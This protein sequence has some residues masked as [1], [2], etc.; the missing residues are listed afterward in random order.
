MRNLDAMLA[1]ANDYNKMF[2][3]MD[4][5]G[6]LVNDILAKTELSEDDMDYVAAARCSQAPA[7]NFSNP[8]ASYNH[9]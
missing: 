5:L 7:K 3:S 8:T 4:A 2:Q 1:R 6:K 9:R